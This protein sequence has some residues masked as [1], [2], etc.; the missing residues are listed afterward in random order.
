M[1]FFTILLL[2]FEADKKWVQG[3][4]VGNQAPVIVSFRVMEDNV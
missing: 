1:V 4:G 2:W 3:I